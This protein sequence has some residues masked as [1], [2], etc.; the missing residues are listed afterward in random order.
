LDNYPTIGYLSNSKSFFPTGT[1]KPICQRLLEKFLAG[2]EG[3]I[4]IF[5]P[6]ID[7]N[8]KTCATQDDARH[9]FTQIT[10]FEWLPL[11]DN[12]DTPYTP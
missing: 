6:E 3:V 11:N 12:Y 9:A 4:E 7:C 8:P 1:F 2:A 5:L 10:P